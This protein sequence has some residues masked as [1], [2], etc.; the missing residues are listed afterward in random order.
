MHLDLYLF[1]WSLLANLRVL[2][3]VA[4]VVVEEDYFV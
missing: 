3:V 2:A 4:L 1:A